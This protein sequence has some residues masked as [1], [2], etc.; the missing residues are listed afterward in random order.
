MIKQPENSEEFVRQCAELGDK[1]TKALFGYPKA[2][3]VCVLPGLMAAVATTLEIRRE[4]LIEMLDSALRD[5]RAK[6]D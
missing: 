3:A 6:D 1:L 5:M 4:T 2:V